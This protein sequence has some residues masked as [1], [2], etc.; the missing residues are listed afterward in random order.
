MNQKSFCLQSEIRSRQSK[1]ADVPC[2]DLSSK[3]NTRKEL[4]VLKRYLQINP[5]NSSAKTGNPDSWNAKRQE[6]ADEVLALMRVHN[7]AA[8]PLL[9]LL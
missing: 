3:Q 7:P 5:S 4:P 2:C 6:F 1:H 8:L 9:N